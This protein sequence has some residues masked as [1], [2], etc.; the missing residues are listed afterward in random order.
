MVCDVGASQRRSVRRA[1][2]ARCARHACCFPLAASRY[3]T[4]RHPTNPTPNNTR[5]QDIDDVLETLNEAAVVY[6]NFEGHAEKIA[7]LR[8]EV[9]KLVTA[10]HEAGA[11][12][13]ALAELAASYQ[14]SVSGRTD[15]EGEI[16]AIM[17]RVSAG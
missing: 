14:P 2:C 4:L 1:A 16:D 17:Q 5:Q 9:L 6:S 11:F 3:K 13:R 15:F 12:K 7:A 8:G 10:Q